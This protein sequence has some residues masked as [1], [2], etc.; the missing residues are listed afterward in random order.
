MTPP[1]GGTIPVRILLF[2]RYAEL[3]GRDHLDV[4]LAVPASVADAVAH[5]RALPGGEVL[6]ARPLC[7]VNHAHAPLEAVLHAG[8][9]LAL[10]P[11][12]AGG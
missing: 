1:T 7:A 3:L 10:L 6:P 9:E 5:V 2:A 8:D 4:A 12:L 11:P